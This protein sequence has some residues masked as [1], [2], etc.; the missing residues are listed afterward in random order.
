M[1][2]GGLPRVPEPPP[3]SSLGAADWD[4][5][6][7]G[8]GPAGAVAAALIAGARLRVLLVDRTPF[9]RAK[10]C[11][12]CLNRRAVAALRNTG[13]WPC[14]AAL[15]PAP[16]TSLRVGFRGKE[17]VLPAP[18][19]AV[20]TR[21]ALDTALAAWAV[22]AGAVF[23]H[24]VRA[25]VHAPSR[26]CREAALGRGAERVAVRARIIIDAGGLMSSLEAKGGA[27]SAVTAGSRVGAGVI[28]R[29]H[30]SLDSAPNAI[31]MAVAERGYVG[32]ARAEAGHLNAA[33]A[34]DPAYIKARGGLGPAAA[35]IV[36][37]AG[38]S[39]VA[40]LEEGSWTGAPALTRRGGPLTGP[41]LFRLGDAAGYVEPFTG[42]G[43][44]WALEAAEAL[45]PLAAKAAARWDA[46]HEARWRAWHRRRIR[47]HQR[48]CRL[49]ALALRSPTC[50]SAALR[51]V[52]VCPALAAPILAYINGPSPGETHAAA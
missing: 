12:G 9:P 26:D 4:V 20:V 33:A 3:L 19:G 50:T 42:E 5:L 6:V 30:G 15:E 39:A 37:A 18:E 32:L 23:A 43:M 11:G 44:A 2:A 38:F 46:G 28:L 25:E 16:Y 17:A 13:C 36:N 7:V 27:R 8:A 52:T 40:G 47:P 1:S 49:I 35:A 51:A 22:E 31:H 21:E 10:V 48:L 24:G 29:D 45:A 41:R 34:L 14:V